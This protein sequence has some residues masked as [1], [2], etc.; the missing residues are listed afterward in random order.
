LSQQA[1]ALPDGR[2]LPVSGFALHRTAAMPSGSDG[3]AQPI[4]ANPSDRT[5]PET[6]PLTDTVLENDPDVSILPVASTPQAAPEPWW[7]DTPERSAGTG[8]FSVKAYAGNIRFENSHFITT[9]NLPLADS[10]DSFNGNLGDDSFYASNSL[11]SAAVR[12]NN[13]ADIPI[14]ET[15]CD[16]PLKAGVSI[17]YD[18]TPRFG[19]ESGLTYSYHHAKQSYAG[20]LNG[21]YYR[22]F[23]LHYLGIP[24]KAGFT[25]VRLERAAFYLNLGGEAELMA[26]GRIRTIDGVTRKSTAVPEHP[27]QFSLLGTAGAEYFFNGRLGLYAEPGLAWH[28]SPTGSLPSYYREHPWSFDLRLG[29]RLRLN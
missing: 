20:N 10:K 1:P 12:L 19:I 9:P 8:G 5:E 18:F 21:S 6:V 27:L 13:V 24:L 3:D 11:L 23:R 2:L 16:L 25:L 26:T 28:P 14:Y 4:I 7:E 29:L 15:L 17:R 22:D